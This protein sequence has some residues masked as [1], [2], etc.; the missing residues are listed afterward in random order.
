[1]IRYTATCVENGD[2]FHSFSETA[3]Y[4]WIANYEHHVLNQDEP[5]EPHFEVTTD[6]LKKGEQHEQRRHDYP[7]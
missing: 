2:S 6:E 1:M 5:W 3:I 7:V 4:R